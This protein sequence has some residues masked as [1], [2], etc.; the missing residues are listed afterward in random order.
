MQSTNGSAATWAR[1]D[2]KVGAG[3]LA[4][5]E[6]G[7]IDYEEDVPEPPPPPPPPPDFPGG[8]D[9]PPSPKSEPPR[10]EK[11]R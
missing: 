7:D 9:N 6:P 10:R 1:P 3:L 8:G 4:H 2:D 11:D 5:P